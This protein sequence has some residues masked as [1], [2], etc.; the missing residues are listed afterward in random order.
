MVSIAAPIDIGQFDDAPEGSQ[1]THIIREGN[2]YIDTYTPASDQTLE[3][4]ETSEDEDDNESEEEYYDR[5]ED[6][7]WENAERGA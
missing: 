3:W 2:A 5:V 4:P 1:I 7:D 6:E